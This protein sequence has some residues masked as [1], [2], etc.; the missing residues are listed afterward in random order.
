MTLQEQPVAPNGTLSPDEG[1]VRRVGFNYPDTSLLAWTPHLPEVAAAAN[2]V[3]LLMPYLEPFLARSLRRVL[4]DLPP[5]L[6]T[7]TQWLIDQ[8]LSHQREHRNF[9]R[10]LRE[11]APALTRVERLMRGFFR[12]LERR[13]S[14]DLVLAFCAGGETVAFSIARWTERHASELFRDADPVVTTLFMWHLA[15]EVEHKSVAFDVQRALGGSRVRYLGGALLALVVLGFFTIV[16]SLTMLH[17]QRRLKNPLAWW[18]LTRWALSLAFEVLPNVF[19]AALASHHP[20][21]IADPTSLV[22]WLRLYDPETG[23]IPLWWRPTT[24]V[25]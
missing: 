16:G 14:R 11:E 10:R 18:R 6:A 17:A 19:A 24:L 3:S 15:E 1:T 5:E 22:A 20:S 13:G 4:A 23:S 7:R 12:R 8:E 25:E 21:R 2:S 9:N